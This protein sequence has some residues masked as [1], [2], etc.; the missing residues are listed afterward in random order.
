[1]GA[2]VIT[3]Y[4]NKTYRIDDVDFGLTPLSKH[5]FFFGFPEI[6]TDV[7]NLIKKL[8]LKYLS[9]RSDVFKLVL[10]I[11]SRGPNKKQDKIV[12]F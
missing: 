7:S 9:L 3:K 8:I 12:L 10:K 1:M 2:I 6:V 11:E 4:N 5:F